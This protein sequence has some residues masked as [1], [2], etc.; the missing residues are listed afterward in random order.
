MRAEAHRDEV[1]RLRL[2]EG[3]PEIRKRD[4]DDRTD[5]DGEVSLNNFGG[6]RH[7]ADGTG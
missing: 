1:T 2:T 6:L 5:D 4:E 7:G 3:A